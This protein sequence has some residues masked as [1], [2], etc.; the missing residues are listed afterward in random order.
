MSDDDPGVCIVTQPHRSRASKDHAHDLADIIT[1]ITTV[2]VV[3][4]NLPV[5]SAL[6]DDHEV[7]EYSTSGAGTN[8]LAEAVRFFLNQ[9]RLCRVLLSRDETVVLF[10]GTTSYLLPVAF[11]RLVGKTV[12]VLPRGDV[13]LSLRLRWEE[14]LGTVV[15]S[16]LAGMVSLLERLNYRLADAVVAYTPAMAAQLGLDRYGEKLYTNG[17]RFVDTEQF[18]VRVPYEEREQTVG[19]IGRLDAEKRIPELAAAAKQLP[20]DV[21]F[22]FVG[23]GD[24]REM[25][26]RKLAEE[27]ER[28]SVEVVGWVDRE[29]VP[30][31][32][33]R[34]RLQIVPSHPT[35][36]LPTAILEGMACGTPAYATPVSGVPDVVLEAETGFLMEDIN[37]E[38]IATTIEAVLER[39]D[40]V[41][42]SRNA[43]T[44][45]ETEYSFEGAID[46]YRQILADIT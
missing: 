3:T 45:I 19:F 1:E 17:A 40:L 35:E 4:A 14:S 2:A 15:A 46:R 32:L 16:I 11:S 43:R 37:G 18:D 36:G 42:I 33:N 34:L 23:D 38:T 24:Y 25:L 21:R 6:G 44:L 12:V 8:V 22:V 39:D 10:F 29:D 5:D 13:P 7:D 9:L 26:E 27:I 28:G 30:E 41:E 31:Q 20:D